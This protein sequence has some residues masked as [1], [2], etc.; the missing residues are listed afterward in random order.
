ML[1]N[2]GCIGL[3]VI[4][5]I[6]DVKNVKMTSVL[7]KMADV[8]VEYLKGQIVFIK[9]LEPKSMQQKESNMRLWIGKTILPLGQS[10]VMPNSDPQ[11]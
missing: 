7:F 5:Y 6:S 4:S 3:H 9:V 10:L 1:L 8:N 11:V 2:I